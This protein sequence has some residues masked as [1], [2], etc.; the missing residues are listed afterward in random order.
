MGRK[1]YLFRVRF[2]VNGEHKSFKTVARS[3]REAAQHLKTK[4]GRIVRVHKVASDDQVDSFDE[5]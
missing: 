3:P 4:G 2:K 1:R 5:P